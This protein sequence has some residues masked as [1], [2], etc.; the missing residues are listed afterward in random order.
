METLKKA[1]GFMVRFLKFSIYTFGFVFLLMLALSF[2]SLP[3]YWHRWLGESMQTDYAISEKPSCIVML[4]GGGMPSESN[5]I[6]LYYCAQL[7]NEFPDA[8]L[9]IAH[10]PDSSVSNQMVRFLHVL[11]VDISRISFSHEGTNTR[12][13]AM[14]LTN[15]LPNKK[16][17]MAMVTAPENMRRSVL[18]FNKVGFEKVIAVPAFENAMFLDLDYDFRKIGGRAY[19][20]DVSASNGLRYD[21]W[22]YLKLEIICIR[23]TFALVYYR[24][25]GWI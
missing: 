10:P 6:R 8:K 16:L 3:F 20:P 21:F 24:I 4:G 5:L 18:A 15:V 2:T 12:A 11:G 14:G 7:A 25:N 9:V 22:N 13:Q 1:F 19:V 23:E 17:T